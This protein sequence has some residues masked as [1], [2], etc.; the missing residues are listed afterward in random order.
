MGYAVPMLV[1]PVR[2]G[3]GKYMSRTPIFP[4]ESHFT[5][6]EVAAFGL[7]A[8]LPRDGITGILWVD[9]LLISGAAAALTFWMARSETRC[10]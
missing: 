10:G 2:K 4:P 8:L 3:E 7:A 5:R 9:L 1:R 6:W